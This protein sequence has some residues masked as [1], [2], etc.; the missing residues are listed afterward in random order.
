VIRPYLATVTTKTKVKTVYFAFDD[1][2]GP[3]TAEILAAAKKYH[4]EVTFFMIGKLGERY[5]E[6][7]RQAAL[8]GDVV[9]NHTYDHVRL[10]TLNSTQ[11]IE[12]LTKGRDALRP[13]VSNC[14]RPPFWATDPTIER[15]G[16]ELGMRQILRTAGR[17]RHK[18]VDIKAVWK[19]VDQ[20]VSTVRNE[21][22]DGAEVTLHGERLG[23]WPQVLAFE[24]LLP[25]LSAEGYEFKPMPGCTRPG[26]Q[27]AA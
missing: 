27:P 17:T 3:G 22:F 16:A 23:D 10:T 7:V 24:K 21:V 13:Y 9:G 8:D 11:V 6:L 12:E 1:G 15:I 14:W 5:P 19:D 2:P 4:A 25:L 26:Y 20:I 18:P